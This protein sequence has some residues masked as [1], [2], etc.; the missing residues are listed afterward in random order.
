MRSSL[1]N[2]PSAL[3]S[4][5]WCAPFSASKRVAHEGCGIAYWRWP[6]A[7]MAGGLLQR[8]MAAL[9]VK[10][11]AWPCLLSVLSTAGE[12]DVCHTSSE[13]VYSCKV[14]VGRKTATCSF[15]PVRCL[16]YVQMQGVRMAKHGQC[17]AHS[18]IP[19]A[20]ASAWPPWQMRCSPCHWHRAC[21]S[22]WRKWSLNT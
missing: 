8:S 4:T 9:C 15:Y 20:S 11:T 16:G 21:V 1:W 13:L 14:Y 19:W 7:D 3:F 12:S 5:S 10:V 6:H 18:S 2:W 17:Q 22:L